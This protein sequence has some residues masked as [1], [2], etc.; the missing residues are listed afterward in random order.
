MVLDAGHMHYCC[1]SCNNHDT[2][3]VK[4]KTKTKT[5]ILCDSVVCLHPRERKLKLFTI[6]KI[7]LHM[8]VFII[9]LDMIKLQ[10]Y[11]YTLNIPCHTTGTKFLHLNLI[12]HPLNKRGYDM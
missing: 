7:G 12:S 2:I 6:I 11:P 1:D 4:K 5:Q 8:R 10:K 9:T 3:G